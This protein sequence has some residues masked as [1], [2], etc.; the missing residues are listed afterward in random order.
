MDSSLT[1]NTLLALFGVMIVGASVPG[2]SV[3]TVS[4][5]SAA[6]GFGHGIFVTLGIVTGD[7]L[8]ILVAIYGLS[9]L[10]GFMGAHFD[11]V[12]YFGGAWLIWLGIALWRSKSETTGPKS[13][14]KSSL[15]S[16][17]LAGLLITLGDQK[18]ILFYLGLF[19]ALFDLPAFTLID[20]G[21]I[22]TI[23]ATALLFSKLVYAWLAARTNAV[24]K[25]DGPG[26]ALNIAAGSVMLGV[27]IFLIMKT[28]IGHT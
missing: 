4:A 15:L 22:I 9:L 16:S 17:Y 5:R 20:T 12:K 10:V 1:F 23:A 8:F 27:G 26:K 13:D 21:I 7:I 24:F 14:N 28:V 6:F 25:G 11:L 3:L 19:P 18:A 2:V